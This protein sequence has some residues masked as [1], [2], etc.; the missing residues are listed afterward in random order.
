MSGRLHAHTTEKASLNFPSWLLYQR[1]R[2]VASKQVQVATNVKRFSWQRR[3][4]RKA[5]FVMGMEGG[6]SRWEGKTE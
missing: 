6:D 4:S 3:A 2:S 5:S 1:V